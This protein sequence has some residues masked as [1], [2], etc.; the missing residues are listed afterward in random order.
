MT[1]AIGSSRN[2]RHLVI[3]TAWMTSTEAV[4]MPAVTAPVHRLDRKPTVADQQQDHQRGGQ[5]V[6][7][8]LAQQLVV[9]GGAGAAGR[10]QPVARLAHILRGKAA[11]HRRGFRRQRG[12]IG[13]FAWDRHEMTL[14]RSKPSCQPR[15]KILK[16]KLK[17]G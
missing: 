17:S 3:M 8:V 2:C 14:L 15:R 9:E 6:L 12:E 16:T 11:L 1:S 4:Q 10:G 5:P 13:L 7:R